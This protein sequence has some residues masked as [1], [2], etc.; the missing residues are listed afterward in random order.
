MTNEQMKALAN[1]RAA[2]VAAETT[3]LTEARDM[4]SG[5]NRVSSSRSERWTALQQLQSDRRLPRQTKK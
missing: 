2:F 5:F 4:E 1:V 3:G